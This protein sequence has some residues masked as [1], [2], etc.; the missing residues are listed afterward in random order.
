MTDTLTKT[1][2]KQDLRCSLCH[3]VCGDNGDD[4]TISSMV[5]PTKVYCLVCWTDQEGLESYIKTIR[6]EA[7][8]FLEERIA[9]LRNKFIADQPMRKGKS[10]YYE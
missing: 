9:R 6:A 8:N 5:K 1:L 7:D 2:V 10:H 3:C 4:Y